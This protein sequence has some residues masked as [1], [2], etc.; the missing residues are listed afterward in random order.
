MHHTQLRFLVSEKSCVSKEHK[1]LAN[2]QSNK[3]EQDKIGSGM[4]FNMQYLNFVCTSAQNI[5]YNQ[6]IKPHNDKYFF[7]LQ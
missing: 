2:W 6:L 5:I 4:V 3:S 1:N 7:L